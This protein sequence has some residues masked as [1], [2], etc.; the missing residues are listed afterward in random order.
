MEDFELR[1]RTVAKY[2]LVI[3]RQRGIPPSDVNNG[4]YTYCEL[5]SSDN[6]SRY[7]EIQYF[8]PWRQIVISVEAFSNNGCRID[9]L[10]A[11]EPAPDYLDNTNYRLGGVDGFDQDE[12]AGEG[13]DGGVVLGRL[14]AA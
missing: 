1:V 2:A 9:L 3:V 7:C 5:P 10:D 4:S 13:D 8:A 11:A 6:R 12:A 14:F